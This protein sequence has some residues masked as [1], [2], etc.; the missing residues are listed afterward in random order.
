MK[1]TMIIAVLLLSVGLSSFT[2]AQKEYGL[3]AGTKA[4][5]F[6]ASNY[7][8]QTVNLSEYYAEGPIVLLFYR[9]AWCPYCNRQLKDF[10][11]HLDGFEPFNAAV[12]AISVDTTEFAAQSAREYN[13]DFEV[14]GN[15]DA[16]ILQDY[17][18]VYQVPEDLN[19]KYRE[20]YGINLKEHSGREDG[21]IAVPAIMIIDA[22]G[23]IVYSYANEDYKVRKS[24][25]EIIEE[26]K[27]IYPS[28][29]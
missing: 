13:L 26:L 18:L 10:Q 16:S 11:D 9:G 17:N 4:P 1:K 21:I 25:E 15:P 7:L 28:E 3:P 5:D 20:E 22:N 8:G 6:S 19:K 29:E 23:R 24:A 12:I 2:W 14:V 27:K